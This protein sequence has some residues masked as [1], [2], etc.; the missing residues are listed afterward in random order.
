MR[1]DLINK[2]L[3]K[4]TIIFIS[5]R[6]SSTK[7]CDRIL[8]LKNGKIVEDGKHDMLMKKQGEYF[9]L[10]NIQKKNYLDENEG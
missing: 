7:F 3:Y 5:H 6:L 2:G 9:C 4:A 10:Y 8:L 1:D